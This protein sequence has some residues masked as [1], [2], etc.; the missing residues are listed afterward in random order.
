MSP[1]PGS[2]AG[3]APRCSVI[4]PT[5][6]R[7][8]TLLRC[9]A[10]L[11][12][13]DLAPEAFEIVVVDDGSTDGTA[14]AVEGLAR[15]AGRAIRLVAQAHRGPSA[16]RN[17][18][19][20][21]ARADVLAFLDDDTIASPSWLDE[22]LRVL[23]EGDAD[24]AGVEGRTEIPSGEGGGPLARRTENLRGRRFLGCNLFFRREAFEEVGGFDERFGRIA[25]REDTDLA[26]RIQ[27]AGGRI[28]WVPTAVVT[29]PA[30]PG[31]WRTPLAHA[32]RYRNDPLLFLKDWRWYITRVDVHTFG[33]V[34]IWKPRPVLYVLY[35]VALP[36]VLLVGP[37]WGAGAAASA[38][39]GILFLHMHRGAPEDARP[40][41]VLLLVAVC[42]VVP[43]VWLGAVFTGWWRAVGAYREN[44]LRV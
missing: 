37:A 39:A 32:W 9:L 41:E 21:V 28:A 31:T 3:A 23:E 11:L 2:P 16:A 18:G 34:S 10:S 1:A 42:A 12:A 26:H 13:Q 20:A 19:A 8:E 35:L 4:I 27:K 5:H 22:G 6:D 40:H 15:E 14:A 33:V 7:R 44:V 24:L 43:A 25:F 38:L 29:H 30:G 36:S 17:A